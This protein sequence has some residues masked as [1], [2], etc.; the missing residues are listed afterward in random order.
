MRGA[1]HSAEEA[2]S[3]GRVFGLADGG[4][5]LAQQGVKILLAHDIQFLDSDPIV[6][7]DTACA[8]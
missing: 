6:R 8:A 1:A 4:A 7:I 3:R 2:A 5:P